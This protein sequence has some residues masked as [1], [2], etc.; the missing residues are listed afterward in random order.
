[1]PG[2]EGQHAPE[3]M[4]I[5]PLMNPTSGLFTEAWN[6]YRAHW[7]HLVPVALVVYLVAALA[8]ALLSTVGEIGAAVG[9]VIH[10]LGVLLVQ[11][12]IVRAV[13]D[14]RDGRADLSLGETYD[15]ARPHILPIAGLA[16]LLFVAV[17]IIATILVG[18]LGPVGIPL[19][20]L[21]GIGAF[22]LYSVVVPVVVLESRGPVGAVQRAR[23]LVLPNFVPVVGI[24]LL[25]FLVFILISLVA[26]IVF[27]FFPDRVQ[28]FLAGIVGGSI[29]ASFAGLIWTLLYYRLRAAETGATT[30]PPS[31]A[32]PPTG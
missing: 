23:E 4:R 19:L 5:L 18:L 3:Q 15:A 22:T 16:L 27:I 17:G 28:E 29:W 2:Q 11:A 32:T 30:P 13:E 8:L 9:R 26:S 20:I 31:G 1:M 24:V 25:T 10:F 6:H 21:V 14:I 7:N 12:A